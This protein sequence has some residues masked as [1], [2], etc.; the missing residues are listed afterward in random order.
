MIIYAGSRDRTEDLARQLAGAGHKAA[1]YHAGMDAV[2]RTT[3][4]DR[5][6][7]GETPIMVATNAFGINIDKPD[8]RAVVH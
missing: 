6:N 2:L 1:A 5:F 8:I 3:R 7:R 4:Q